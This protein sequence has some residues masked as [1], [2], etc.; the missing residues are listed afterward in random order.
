MVC[1][2]SYY[3]GFVGIFIIMFESNKTFHLIE[4]N[5]QNLKEF[6]SYILLIAILIRGFNINSVENV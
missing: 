4:I 1:T 3:V 2:F 5:N 6:S